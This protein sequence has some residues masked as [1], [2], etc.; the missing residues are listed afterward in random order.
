MMR[1]Q[2][3]D[4]IPINWVSHVHGNDQQPV[5]DVSLRSHALLTD[6]DLLIVLYRLP[7]EVVTVS[8]MTVFLTVF[9]TTLRGRMMAFETFVN[10]HLAR[11]ESVF[12][13][14]TVKFLPD[15]TV[16]RCK[17]SSIFCTIIR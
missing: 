17:T 12:D 13:L 1:E 8:E 2:S 16:P 6:P 14:G 11:K 3:S 5:N 15:N 10:N 9:S 4:V 7:V